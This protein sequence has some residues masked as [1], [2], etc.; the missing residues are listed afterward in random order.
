MMLRY[1]HYLI[2]NKKIDISINID[3]STDLVQTRICRTPVCD[4]GKDSGDCC[5]YHRV[6]VRDRLARHDGDHPAAGHVL[7][8]PVERNVAILPQ[9]PVRLPGLQ[10]EGQSDLLQVGL[11][12]ALQLE[13]KLSVGDVGDDDNLLKEGGHHVDGCTTNLAPEIFHLSDNHSNH[14]DYISLFHF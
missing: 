14:S 5:P 12:A 6:L 11:H 8:H 1:F 13:V 3:Y 10:D 7:H 4:V 2:F 9:E